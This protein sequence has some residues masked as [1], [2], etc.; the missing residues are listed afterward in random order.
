MGSW[1]WFGWAG[2]SIR[3]CKV[4]ALVEW[5]KRGVDD[6]LENLVEA[7]EKWETEYSILVTSS[8]VDEAK[9]REHRLM[10]DVW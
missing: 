9:L 8:K 4:V 5:G 6:A 10:G 3:K 2:G 1:I 7:R